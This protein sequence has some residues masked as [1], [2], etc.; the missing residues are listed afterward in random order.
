MAESLATA[1]NLELIRTEAITQH[2]W[3]LLC[4]GTTLSLRFPGAAKPFRVDFTEPTVKRRLLHAAHTREPLA[5]AIDVK[6]GEN[7]TVVDC[8]LGW[9]SDALVLAMLG[10]TVIGIE[11]SPIVAALLQNGLDRAQQLPEFHS[12]SLTIHVGDSRDLL[13]HFPTPN[14]IYLDPMFP[15][16]PNSALVKKPLQLL[17]QLLPVTEDAESLAI[18]AL[19]QHAPRTVIKRPKWAPPLLNKPHFSIPAGIV[20]FDIYPSQGSTT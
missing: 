1:L 4:D 13:P 16:T 3:V 5:R 10:A 20:R 6:A 11:R 9:G 7:F 14:A 2:P 18:L 17:Q 12:L 19:N 15:N 8:T